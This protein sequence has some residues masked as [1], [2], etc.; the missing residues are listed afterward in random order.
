MAVAY[1]VVTD[2]FTGLISQPLFIA[3]EVNHFRGANPDCD[4]EDF[5]CFS[6]VLFSGSSFLHLVLVA[7]DRH[8]AINNPYHYKRRITVSRLTGASIT[9]WILTV[10]YNGTYFIIIK[11]SMDI[12]YE[13]FYFFDFQYYVGVPVVLLI[14]VYWYVR[15]FLTLRAARRHIHVNRDMVHS[16]QI[17]NE[18]FQRLQNQRTVFTTL[19]LVFG[20]L[21]PY[22]ILVIFSVLIVIFG[23][24]IR[25]PLFFTLLSISYSILLLNSLMNPIVFC[26]RTVELKT[27]SLKLLGFVPSQGGERAADQARSEV[28]MQELELPVVHVTTDSNE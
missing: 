12:P 2:F 9:I 22:T 8:V 27:E 5:F 23:E 21:I 26:L 24:S 7:Y 11:L 19:I 20:F 1:L 14:M 10:I 13:I 17:R 3:R 16:L 28:A 6:T 25:S 18:T 4:V 15:I